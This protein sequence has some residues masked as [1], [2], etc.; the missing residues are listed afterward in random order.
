MENIQAL[1]VTNPSFK[2][3]REKDPVVKSLMRVFWILLIV[4]IVEI[5]LAFIHYFWHFPPRALLNAVFIGL[6]IVKA[7]YI[8]GEFMHLRHEIKTLILL[9]LVP[10]VFLF[11]AITALIYEGNSTKNMRTDERSVIESTVPW[12]NVIHQND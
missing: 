10:L 4:T 11:W 6:T 3:E 7:F 12:Q 9:F 8:I 2:E 5:G 1:E